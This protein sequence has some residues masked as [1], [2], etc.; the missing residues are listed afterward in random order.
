MFP[1][2]HEWMQSLCRLTQI[3]ERESL[4]S[5]LFETFPLIIQ[6][7]V[8]D[9]FYGRVESQMES[10]Q[11]KLANKQITESIEGQTGRIRRVDR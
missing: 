9:S 1:S 6:T 10:K 3:T 4:Y 8:S 11:P 7:F 5:K 2:R